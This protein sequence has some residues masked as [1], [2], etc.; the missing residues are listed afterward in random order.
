MA[1]APEEEVTSN[2]GGA[3]PGPG[4]RKSSALG[5]NPAPGWTWK[6]RSPRNSQSPRCGPPL[7]PMPHPAPQCLVGRASSPLLQAWGGGSSAPPPQPMGHATRAL[8][9]RGLRSVLPNAESGNPQIP[10]HHLHGRRTPP[11]PDVWEP[12][13]PTARPRAGQE[14]AVRENPPPCQDGGLPPA[15]PAPHPHLLRPGPHLDPTLP[16]RRAFY[17]SSCHRKVRGVGTTQAHCRCPINADSR[18]PTVLMESQ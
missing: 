11:R 8:V 10:A 3:H 14:D 5:E 9:F 18:V 2:G 7:R 4:A 16:G 1:H 17:F 12:F 6:E 15:H 13:V